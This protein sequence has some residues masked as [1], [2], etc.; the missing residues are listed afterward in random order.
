MNLL[1]YAFL[2]LSTPTKQNNMNF[3][4]LLQLSLRSTKNNQITFSAEKTNIL[5]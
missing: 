2:D 4:L 5:I 3:K 1:Q